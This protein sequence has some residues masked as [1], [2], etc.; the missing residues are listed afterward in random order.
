MILLQKKKNRLNKLYLRSPISLDNY[1]RSSVYLK[2]YPLIIN[3]FIFIN[4][5]ISRKY[6]NT[7]LWLASTI[8]PTMIQA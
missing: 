6:E 4:C 7:N 1:I 3:L 5:Y 2:V 8:Y